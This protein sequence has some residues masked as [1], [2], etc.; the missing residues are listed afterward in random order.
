MVWVIEKDIKMRNLIIKGLGIILSATLMIGTNSC[1]VLAVN[2]AENINYKRLTIEDGLSQ[3]AATVIFQDSDGY[4]WI[5]T[6]DGLNKYNG[7]KFE[8]YKNNESY[9][10]S[11]SGN[12]I[13]AIKEDKDNNLWV[14]TT[15]GLNKINL[16]SNEVTQYIPGEDGCNISSYE[17]MDIL[18]ND[19]GE[20]LVA[21][22]D[23]LNLYD[24]KNN[25]FIRLYSSTHEGDLVTSQ[26][27]T[28]I[29]DDQNGFYWI[30]T[31]KGL[32]RVDKANDQ[33]TKY[34]A[35][36]CEENTISIDYIN[37]L[38]IDDLNNLWIGTNF[39][40]LNK[41]SLENGS[42]EKF[43]P[44]DDSGLSGYVINDIIQD[45]RG[46]LWVSTDFGVSQYDYEKN[47][48]K[49]YRNKAY[50]SNSLINNNTLSIYED[51]SGAIWVGTFN[52]VS[53]FYPENMFKIYNH[54]IFNE[55][56]ISDNSIS[57][58]YED[59]EGLLWVGTYTD[60]LNIID[61]KNNKVER[62][63]YINNTGE[64]KLSNN[65]IR[66]ITGIDNEIWIATQNGLH[67][68]DKLTNEMS[69]YYEEHGLV[70]SDLRTV[71]IDSDGL[72]WIGTRDG[73]GTF[74]RDNTFTDYT[75]LLRDAGIDEEV[76]NHI[77]ED[78]DGTIWIASGPKGGLIRYDKD[79][80]TFKNYN[81]FSSKENSREYS[82]VLSVTSDVYGT[83]WVST[84]NGL[85]RFNKDTED[86]V[87]YT[88]EQGL[89]NNWIYGVLIDQQGNLW[90]STNYGISKF[91]TKEEKFINYYKADG[92]QGNEFNQFSYYK[93]NS[94]EMFFGGIEGLTSFYPNDIKDKNYVPDIKI[95]SIISGGKTLNIQEPIRLNYKNEH[96][97][98]EFFMPDYRD[99]TKIQYVYKMSG[100]DKQWIHSGNR[101][102]VN[103]TNLKPGRYIFEVIGRNSSGEWSSAIS[104]IIKID[105]P[106]WKTPIAYLIY[107]IIIISIVLV[108]W[109]SF[110]LLNALVEQRT[111]ELNNK[112]DENKELYVKLLDHEK[113]KNNYFVN[114]S[115]ELR[116]P[117]NIIVSVQALMSDLNRK[118]EY[119]PKDKMNYYL[120]SLKTNSNRLLNLI[121]NIINTS[122]IESGDYKINITENDIVYV[123]E[124]VVLSTRELSDNKG[125]ELIIDPY[126]EEKVIQCDKIEIEKAILNLMSNAIKFTPK[127]GKIEVTIE[128][129]DDA[130]KISVKDNGIGIDPKHQ[131]S[132]FNRFDQAY[133]NS[134][135]E[136]GGSGLGLTV[137]RQ[138][139]ELHGGEI[140]VESQLGN[141]SE[142]I[143]ILP[144]QVI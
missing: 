43:T 121:N 33:V 1:K 87:K 46:D 21:T 86:F 105:N 61:R 106:P 112:L 5:G 142:F 23:G 117:L 9:E 137:T 57:G 143:I 13:S 129:L 116:T 80:N 29:V 35:N 3:T 91:N 101:N 139:I 81:N 97:Q 10:T 103:Y 78:K 120:N 67:K 144:T 25:N 102:Y 93:S 41:L 7:H 15:T 44:D 127:G 52:G 107:F 114:L 130:V 53:M 94:G 76:F 68:Y 133:E 79:T 110:K 98:I 26:K 58:I 85:V 123:V 24:E 135:E 63:D 42:I 124:E 132:I 31:E 49:S 88:E 60:G 47:T 40:G 50:E 125:I 22:K 8:V 131:E 75:Y 104:I 16:I 55:N 59:K 45:S 32:N 19:N 30:G 74:D 2:N 92:L 62:I 69:I 89:P 28:S 17:I 70:N 119:I 73:L 51:R 100:V 118:N 134:I 27:I 138:L 108:I 99:T 39:G 12:T 71:F 66:E 36:E 65:L 34:F 109:N 113:S 95:N 122:K 18:I 126:I 96:V 83:I 140:W 77:H 38:Y 136:F 90:I 115:H 6:N 141:G 82:Y 11:I 72:L 14:G 37:K 54:D 20:V 4:I 48:F 111:A 64:V 128:D 56:S 84:D